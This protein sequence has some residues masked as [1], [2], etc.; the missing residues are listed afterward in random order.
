MGNARV[1]RTIAVLVGIGVLVVAAGIGGALAA[2]RAAHDAGATGLA[3][4]AAA[5]PSAP[6]VASATISPSPQPTSAPPTP[7]STSVPPR[8]TYRTSPPLTSGSTYVTSQGGYRVRYPERFA[9]VSR[10]FGA[11][12][13]G[14]PPLPPPGPNGDPD[15]GTF[16]MDIELWWNS[17]R[18][19]LSQY[20]G[21]WLFKREVL[22]RNRT[23]IGGR[24]AEVVTV[25]WARESIEWRYW[26]VPA[27]NPD[28]MLVLRA[29]P[30]NGPD[31]PA[32]ETI[33]ASVSFIAVAPTD[34]RVRV[35]REGALATVRVQPEIVA[36]DRIEAKFTR[37]DAYWSSYSAPSPPGPQAI[38]H[39]PDAPVWVVGVGGAIT[40]D[41]SSYSAGLFAIDARTGARLHASFSVPAMWPPQFDAIPDAK[42]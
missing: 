1:S 36:V 34:T 38:T 20:V 16:R 37:W 32:A 18:T 31:G 15:P 11:V 24:E 42:R 6:P 19:S 23:T 27:T 41:K 14:Y 5:T 7:G 25:K 21:E 4:P 33:A 10:D 3:T 26:F 30:Y 9:A 8:A 28:E 29:R 39:E 12:A 2:F 35:S 13:I 40:Y 17:A 22:A